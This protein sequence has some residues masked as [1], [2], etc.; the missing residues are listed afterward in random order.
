[1][2]FIEVKNVYHAFKLVDKAN[3]WLEVLQGVSLDIERESFVTLLGPSGCGKTTLLRV[4][5]GLIS[6]MAGEVYIDGHLV[7]G[8]DLDR[9]MVFQDFNLLPW[10]TTL[11]NVEFG[12]E[13][14]GHPR[15]I[16][17]EKAQAAIVAVG[18]QG[19]E[20]SFPYQLSG[21]MRQRVGLARALCTDPQT[22]LMDEPFCALDPQIRELMQ[23]ELLKLW[24][25]RKRTVVFV[26]H[27]IDEAIFL[28]DYVVLFTGR[29]GRLR[30]TVL[31]DLPRPRWQNAV[32]LKASPRFLEY[33]KDLWEKL[34]EEIAFTSVQV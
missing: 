18:L 21:G 20:S 32:A 17:K 9:A 5:D 6:P 33:R 30:E 11:G 28:S 23:I 3:P 24:G 34:K 7:T 25:A 31:I 2:A 29:P 13:L 26:T 10:R 19:F 14:Q 27:S 12:L 1:M 16:R 22:L 4:I 8:P 15:A